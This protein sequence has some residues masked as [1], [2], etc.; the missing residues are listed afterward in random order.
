MKTET[1]TIIKIACVYTGIIFGAGF[2]S[3]QELMAFF[4]GHGARGMLAAA[5]AG[6]VLALCGWAVLDICAREKIGSY[7]DFM[8]AVFGKRLGA[9]L[10]II[11]GLFIFIIFAAMLAGFGAS[12]EQVFNVPFSAGAVVLAVICFAVLLFDAQGVVKINLVAT[13]FLVVGAVALGL[14]S[15]TDPAVPAFAVSSV[16]RSWP[17]SSLI[18]ASYNI[19]T[20]TAILA[21]LGGIVTTRRIAKYSGILG[22]IFVGGI[23]LLFT[24]TLWINLSAVEGLEIPMLALAAHQGAF[25]QYSYMLLLMLAIFTTAAANAFAAVKWLEGRLGFRG[26][27]IGVSVCILAVCAAHLGFSVI[28]SNLYSFFGY[29]GIFKV[30]AILIYFFFGRNKRIK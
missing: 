23:A 27:R 17:F 19:L 4:V 21:S 1:K 13:P 7:V 3:G 28:V 24:T 10:D 25:A 9:V 18:Y 15:I 2:A 12:V 20:A 5:L 14:A 16:T 11:V 6:V 29:L 22:G 8:A 26:L 30:A